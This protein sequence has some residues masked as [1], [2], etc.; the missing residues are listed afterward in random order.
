[1]RRLVWGAWLDGRP[2]R[3]VAA[4]RGAAAE[5]GAPRIFA[6]KGPGG[7]SRA[8]LPFSHLLLCQVVPD[9]LVADPTKVG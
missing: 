3:G 8:F 7:I 6:E 4:P 5:R 9:E 1:M 2:L